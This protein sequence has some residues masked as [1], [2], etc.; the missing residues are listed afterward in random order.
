MAMS[1]ARVVVPLLALVA[2]PVDFFF[3]S[4]VSRKNDVAEFLGPF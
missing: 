3:D 4:C 1:V 2:S